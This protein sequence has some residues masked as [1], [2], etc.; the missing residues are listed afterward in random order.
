MPIIS[1]FLGISVYIQYNEHNPPHFHAKYGKY[2]ISITITDGLITGSFPKR[3]LKLV[4]EWYELHVN[5]LLEDWELAEKH[6]PLKKIKPL[7]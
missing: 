3:A 4:L 2:K 1:T 5:E 7:E 6:K